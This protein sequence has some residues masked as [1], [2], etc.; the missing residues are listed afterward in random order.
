MTNMTYS[1]FSAF[2][3]FLKYIKKKYAINEHIKFM[4]N[5]LHPK[6]FLLFFKI[7]FFRKLK[8]SVRY[9]F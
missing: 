9:T 8:S 7:L 4:G 3:D 5:L 1:N 2:N 6:A